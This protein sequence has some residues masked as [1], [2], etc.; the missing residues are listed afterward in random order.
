[1]LGLTDT[2]NRWRYGYRFAAV[3]PLDVV[4][5]ISPRP[6]LLIHG[7]DDRTVPAEHA[8][9]LYAAAGE[10]KELWIAPG[11]PHCGAYFDDRAHYVRKV[12]YFSTERCSEF[13]RRARGIKDAMPTIEDSIE[14]KA[15]VAAVFAALTDPH[16]TGEWNPNIIE[17]CDITD[18]RTRE[19]T[20]WRQVAM[21][22]GRKVNLTCRIQRFEPP[23]LGELDIAGDQ[24]GRCLPSVGRHPRVRR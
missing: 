15:P 23:Y 8:R 13:T 21:I 10:P 3:R 1:M 7:Q 5:C 14:I 17:V 18:G 12:A 20:S 9:Q 19:G 22:A 6:L 11:T 16:R 24:R 4:G 2:V